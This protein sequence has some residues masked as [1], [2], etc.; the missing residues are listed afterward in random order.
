MTL[1]KDVLP[2]WSTFYYQQTWDTFPSLTNSG[3]ISLDLSIGDR[4]WTTC[5]G[6]TVG[7]FLPLL[8]ISDKVGMDD[9]IGVAVA[10]TNDIGVAVVDIDEVGVAEGDTGDVGVM[11]LDIGVGVDDKDWLIVGKIKND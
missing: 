8:V 9:D 10:N 6:E 4:T 11:D 7:M 5:T 2:I 1:G 3:E